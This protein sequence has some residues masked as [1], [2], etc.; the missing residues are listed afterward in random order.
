MKDQKLAKQEVLELDID[1]DTLVSDFIQWEDN[2]P[3]VEVQSDNHWFTITFE[4]NGSLIESPC[5]WHDYDD[6]IEINFSGEIVPYEITVL[7][8]ETEDE[9]ELK[10]TKQ[11]TEQL[12]TV[13]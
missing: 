3:I 6:S 1:F 12:K 8:K 10:I 11:I 13:R 5:G 9:F 2:Y 7:N 4:I